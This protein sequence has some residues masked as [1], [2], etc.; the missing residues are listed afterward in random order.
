MYA[1][2]ALGLPDLI[3]D[4][5]PV[6]E[7][8]AAIQGALQDY[9]YSPDVLYADSVPINDSISR[10]R[11]G[12]PEYDGVRIGGTPGVLDGLGIPP[13]DYNVASLCVQAV[14]ETQDGTEDNPE[15]LAKLTG[16]ADSLNLG[17][18]KE[19]PLDVIKLLCVDT[20]GDPQFGQVPGGSGGNGMAGQDP[21]SIFGDGSVTFAKDLFQYELRAL[22]GS[23]VRLRS[24]SLSQEVDVLYME[25]QRYATEND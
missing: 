2:A 11:I 25:S 9:G 12:S 18:T 17:V 22:T 23:P 16:L 4:I 21:N 8:V 20:I 3:S 15:A 13:G 5:N 14:I 19:G 24:G 7:I 1:K 6:D 10:I